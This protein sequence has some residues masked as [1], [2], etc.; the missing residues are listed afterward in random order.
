VGG[1]I[2]TIALTVGCMLLV[3]C[4]TVQHPSGD[5]WEGANRKIFWFN[6]EVDVHVLEPVA[7]GWRW[8]LPEM[9]RTGFTNFFQNLGTPVVAVNQLLQGKPLQGASDTGRFLV[10]TIV[11]LGFIDPA[12]Q[13]GLKRHDEDF[14]QTLAVW[15]VPGGPYLVIP[16]LGPSNARDLTGLVVDTAMS[17]TP[18]FVDGWI[19]TTARVVQ[20]VNARSGVI[21]RV[22]E[23]KAASLDYY[24]AVR[25][26]YQ[27]RRAAAIRDDLD[28]TP[29]TEENEL[30]YPGEELKPQ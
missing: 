7:K 9:V 11:G 19:L 18:F 13:W 14:G 6:D 8:A 20:T 30:Y 24:S 17:I 27:Q 16:L 2:R 4:S 12:S 28:V 25:N 29:A 21:D 5:P 15:G 22:R 26:G 23:V 10:N 1:R 3:A